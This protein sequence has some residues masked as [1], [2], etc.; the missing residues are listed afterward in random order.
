MTLYYQSIDVKKAVLLVLLDRSAAFDMIDHKILVSRL[1][2]RIGV[3]GTALNWSQSYLEGWSSRVEIA[4]N[5]S[6]PIIANFG[7]PQGSVVGPI[8][9]SI[10]TL[11]AGD[12]AR[13]HGVNYH[14][15]VYRDD[16][17]LCL[18]RPI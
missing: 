6:E 3:S 16:T 11:P 12:I 13:H 9:Y 14:V 1:S 4:G 17:Q 7:L 8:R 15:L 18:L 10:C 2:K 5:L